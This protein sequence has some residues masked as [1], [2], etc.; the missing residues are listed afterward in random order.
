[1]R[2]ASYNGLGNKSHLKDRLR[3]WFISNR[4]E[5]VYYVCISPIYI[6]IY[7]MLLDL[8]SLYKVCK[9]GWEFAF[10]GKPEN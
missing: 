8:Y 5:L 3:Q 4:L 10:P 2:N 9:G 7:I 6:Y 1:M